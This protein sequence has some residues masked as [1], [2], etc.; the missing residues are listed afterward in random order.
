MGD[1]SK[2]GPDPSVKDEEILQVFRATDDPALSTAEVAE[3]LP[4]K[5]RSVYNHLESL[6]DEG[7]LEKKTVG[8]RNSVWWIASEESET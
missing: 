5:R 6:R 3:E 8:G 4:L 2:P 7:V 1:D